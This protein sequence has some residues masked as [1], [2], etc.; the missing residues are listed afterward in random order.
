V[1]DK[2]NQ[3]LA[4][5]LAATLVATTLLTGAAQAQ[6]PAARPPGM[7]APTPN[8]RLVSP[9]VAADRRVTFRL[10]APEARTVAVT[11]EFL[12]WGGPPLALA[13]GVD[14]VWTGTSDA[15]PAGAYRYAFLMDGVQVVDPRNPATSASLTQAKSLLVV[16]D[17]DFAADRPGVPHGAIARVRYASPTLGVER[18][19]Q[20]YT[21]PGYGRDGKTY[22]VLYLLHG[23][24]DADDSWPTV[25]R[26]GFILDNLIAEKKTPPMI[27]VM[28]AGAVKPTGQPMTWDA[29]QDP[30]TADLLGAVMPYVEANYRVSKAPGQ[31]A[32]AGLSMGGIQTLNIGLT[33][34]ERF[35][36]IG[37]FSSGW[38]PGDLKAF[39]DHNGADLGA[40]AARLKLFYYSN[41][42]TD[43]ALPQ[44]KKAFEMFDRHGVRV[45][46]HAFPGGHEW[47]VWR[48]S[49]YDFAQ[50]LFR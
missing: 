16:S 43:I 4:R 27:V 30:F 13:K 28:P 10:Y 46:T 49:L 18:Q 26:A 21:P 7:P 50:K 32:L 36:W 2:M 40:K 48:A 31:T 12:A 6:P 11:G 1:T 14:G 33:H 24:G 42:E 41:G 44:A 15:L 35:N 45:E 17:D 34:T 5:T 47:S 29:G 3:T 37:V 19:M 25:G 39:E 8:D 23:G 9:E 20:V 38:F 22:P